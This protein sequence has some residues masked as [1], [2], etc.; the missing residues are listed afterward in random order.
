MLPAVWLR[1][2]S[3]HGCA[4]ARAVLKKPAVV[5]AGEGTSDRGKMWVGVGTRRLIDHMMLHREYAPLMW[6]FHNG[7]ALT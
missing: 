3:A 6:H 5:A 4:C 1:G 7:C 2:T